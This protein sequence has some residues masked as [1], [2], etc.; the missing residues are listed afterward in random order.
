VQSSSCGLAKLNPGF[1]ATPASGGQP[2]VRAW[3]PHAHARAGAQAACELRKLATRTAGAV[4]A[5]AQSGVA[6][7]QMGELLH[8]ASGAATR[9][10]AVHASSP[11]VE[12]A[13]GAG[14][15]GVP[16]L[17]GSHAETLGAGGVRL[18]GH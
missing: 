13:L 11:R 2:A 7:Q 12:Q 8:Y 4:G 9:A 10:A 5:A 16:A 1:V 15:P 17:A 3:R 14:R 18:R 6:R